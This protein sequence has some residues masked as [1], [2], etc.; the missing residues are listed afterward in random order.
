MMIL[1]IAVSTM[2][3]VAVVVFA[4]QYYAYKKSQAKLDKVCAS[5]GLAEGAQEMPI[6]S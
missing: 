3:I 5:K 4:V 2:I 1:A 6:A